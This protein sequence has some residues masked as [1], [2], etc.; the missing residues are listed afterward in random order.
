MNRVLGGN[1]GTGGTNPPPA[2]DHG[3]G[4][5]AGGG[6]FL[7][8][9]SSGN[10][11]RTSIATNA[12]RGGAG[13]AGTYGG[14]GGSGSGAGI[15]SASESG[16]PA[17]LTFGSGTIA[18]NQAFGGPAGIRNYPE[19]RWR[20]RDRRRRDVGLANHRLIYQEPV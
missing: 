6:V 18:G 7:F 9:G 16:N 15:W 19:W 10:F 2:T 8:I 4:N 11:V 1:A 3:G 14:D 12:A 20:L 13:G 17:T 5:A